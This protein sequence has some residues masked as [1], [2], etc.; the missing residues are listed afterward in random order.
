M[1]VTAEQVV[2]SEYQPPPLSHPDVRYVT[3]DVL[4]SSG[5]KFDAVFSISI[6][7][8]DGSVVACVCLEKGLRMN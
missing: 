7:E 4:T 2:V 3:P 1:L 6:I 8:H 5:E